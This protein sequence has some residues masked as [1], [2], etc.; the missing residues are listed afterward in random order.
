MKL[1]NYSLNYSAAIAQGKMTIF[2]FLTIC[3]ELG[4]EGA[5]LN[6]SNL[7]DTRRETL[8]QVRRAYLDH[9]LSVSMFTDSTNFARAG[10]ENERPDGVETALRAATFL[11]APLLRVFAGSAAGA[12]DRPRAWARAVAGAR[13]VCDQA[14]Q[15]GLP[16]GLQNHNHGA[17]CGT[18]D[19][20]LRFLK[21]VAHPNLTYVLDCGQFVGSAGASGAPASGANAVELYESIR[22]TAVLARYVR[23][24]FYN[25]RPDGSEPYIDYAKVFDILRSVHYAGFLDVVYEPIPNRG[26]PIRTALPRIVGF[27]RAQLRDEAPP[28]GRAAQTHRADRYAGLDN[29]KYL[30]E[31][32]LR[33]ETDVAFLEGPTVDRS[34]VVY[35][36]NVKEEQVL[37]WDPDK[38]RLG[39]FRSNSSGANGLI[40]DRQGRLLA[41]EGVGRVTRTDL[42]TG[43][44]TVLAS[45]YQGQPLGGP[46]DLDLDGQGRIYFTARIGGAPPP[47]G[48]GN[49]NAVYRID[50]D[51]SLARILATPEIDM[52]NGIAIAPDD[53]TLY[54][55]DADAR[56]ERARR[57]RAYHLKPDGT[58]AN[59]RTLY[60]F[61]PGRSGDGMSA[62]AEGNLYVMA[63]LHR[64]RGSSETLD[65]RP[66]LHVISPRGKLLAFLET[67][68]DSVTNCAFGGPDRRTLYITCGKLLLSVRTR[69][70]G[71]PV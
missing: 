3:R 64:R 42:T 49:V 50:L 61:Y 7:P 34:G 44:I 26:E 46:N 28:A 40:F 6:L 19:D 33:V 1:S 68:E 54:L 55:I 2:D 52:P 39:V 13:K 71:K 30:D 63:G 51:G 24:K 69:I 11:G 16:V 14:A 12:E 41:C 59:E 60:D 53:R 15:V 70:P 35:F 4:L 5:S 45:Q 43:M 66:G 17:L 58:V 21:E 65:T 32:Q 37:T 8:A 20:V 22:R 56:A 62:D 9:G 23:V 29:D 18:A 48:K 57:I 47:D 67:P 31:P 27:L 36:T 38:K 10:D 25:P